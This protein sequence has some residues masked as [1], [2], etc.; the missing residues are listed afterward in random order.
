[1]DWFGFRVGVVDSFYLVSVR[2]P[3][4]E[5]GVERA[6]EL[7]GVWQPESIVTLRPGPEKPLIKG[8][9]GRLFHTSSEDEWVKEPLDSPATIACRGPATGGARP[10][11]VDAGDAFGP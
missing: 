3:N 4:I 10:P 11:L 7:I 5:R 6:L 2:A 9:T 1:M 8:A